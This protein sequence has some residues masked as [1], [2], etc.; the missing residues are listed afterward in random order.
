VQDFDDILNDDSISLVVINT[1]EHTHYDLGKKALLAGKNVIVEKAFTVT[2]AEAQ[3]LIDIARANNRLLSVFQNSRWNGDF[4]TVQQIIREKLLGQLMQYEAHYDRFR[5]Y[6]QPGTWKEEARP[7][8]G[9]LY[10]LGSHMID[11]A[12]VLFGWPQALLA[13]ISTERP[14]GRVS[15]CFEVI[16]YYGQ[17]KVTL[18]SSYLVREP[19]PRY[20]LHG[21]AG[22][23]IKYGVDPQE[24]FLKAG[25]SP[26]EE[27]YGTEPE[28]QWGKLNTTLNGLHFEGRI[29]TIPGSYLR[30]Y[31]N[32][33]GAITSNEPL[34][35]KPE[36]ALQ[37][38]RIIEA[39]LKSHAEKRVIDLDH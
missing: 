21:T 13:D 2:S 31:E 15:D 17:L 36:Q 9:S 18:K 27:G 6:I 28:Q 33:Y 35:V 32:I 25:G 29:A 39:A 4:L 11:Q 14:G 23:F 12:L 24:A 8:T 3:E 10:N 1:P 26:L 7:G 16:L 37:T 38:I 22:S 30:F 34:W 19:G 20:M 5:N